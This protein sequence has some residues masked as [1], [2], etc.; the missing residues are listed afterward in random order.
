MLANRDDALKRLSSIEGHLR[1]IRKMIEEDVYCVDI[2]K[3]TYAVEKALDKLDAA[4]LT[5][6]LNHCVPE[7][8]AE[9]RADEVVAELEELFALAR[10]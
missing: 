6:H 3:Q 7:G 10:R 8:M 2:L 4:L 5:G 1:G 9:G